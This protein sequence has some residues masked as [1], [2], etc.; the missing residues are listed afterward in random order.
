MT[1]EVD[2]EDKKQK[3]NQL[4]KILGIIYSC[5]SLLLVVL[6]S[7]LTIVYSID[8]YIKPGEFL[9][10]ILPQAE[11]IIL[12]SQII[13]LP[14]VDIII[15]FFRERKIARIT[16]IIRL[17]IYFIAIT[18]S[19]V[20][21]MK[22]DWNL[23]QDYP[24]L[25]RRDIPLLVSRYLLPILVNIPIVISIFSE[26][27]SFTEWFGVISQGKIKKIQLIRI[28]NFVLFLL[29][30]IEMILIY[31]LIHF[32]VLDPP[33]APLL[34]YLI[35]STSVYYGWFVLSEILATKIILHSKQKQ[36][37]KLEYD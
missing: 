8:Y 15:L 2:V 32:F 35:I 31:S 27:I 5:V 13:I 20:L 26:K 24:G 1:V 10:N 36:T 14:I 37:K 6:F 17:V 34:N 30:L 11:L 23:W 21:L 28:F 7:T 9:V 16:A 3:N 18:I 33:D 25:A 12:V 4:S 29:T 19:L 22:T